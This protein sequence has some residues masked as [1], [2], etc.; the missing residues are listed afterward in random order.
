MPILNASFLHTQLGKH[1][2]SAL[3]LFLMIFTA[4]FEKST[5]YISMSVSSFRRLMFTASNLLLFQSN[6]LHSDQFQLFQPMSFFS[7]TSSRSIQITSWSLDVGRNS[8]NSDNALKFD[9]RQPS[10]K[11]CAANGQ[12]DQIVCARHGHDLMGCK[13]PVHYP[14][15]S[16]I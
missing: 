12:V 16:L 1:Q 13:S 4:D 5:S 8:M 3:G 10:Q 7:A 14:E 11:N 6:W 15:R 2:N 9:K